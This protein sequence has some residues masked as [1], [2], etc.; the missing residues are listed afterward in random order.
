MKIKK[1]P[2]IVIAGSVNSSRV[3]LE[4]MIQHEMNITGVLGLSP[5]KSKGVSGYNDLGK[6]ADQYNLRFKYFDNINSED[7]IDF[8]K[9]SDP[10]LLFVVG[11]SQLVKKPLLGIP[12]EGCV[13]FHP[14]KLP[15]GRGR[16]AVAWLVLGE[17]EGAATFFKLEES[18]DSGPIIIQEPFD[19]DDSDY[20]S[21]VV[22]KI[23]QSIQSGLDKALPRIKNGNLNLVEQDHSKATY[24]GRRRPKDGLINWKN[25]AKKIHTLLRAVS[26][27]LPGAY[28]YF[29]GKK[30]IIN[31]AALVKK[32]KFIG[33]PGRILSIDNEKGVL[34][35]AGENQLL[36]EEF[37]GI[38]PEELRVGVSFGL[39]YEIEFNRLKKEVGMLKEQMNNE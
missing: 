27:P 20:A 21:D 12:S 38:N 34:V 33:V 3:S 8:I 28:T 18:M 37:N 19:V 23:I 5:S 2:K 15:N 11:L 29:K 14:T 10:D 31:R 35:Q 7:S 16:G 22:Q 39:N 25:K 13:G 32:S 4:K 9:E 6:I 26:S 36:L 17:A 24:L 30:V 1:N